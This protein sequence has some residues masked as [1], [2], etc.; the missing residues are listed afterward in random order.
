MEDAS[1]ECEFGRLEGIV[2]WEMDAEEEYT[3]VIR[4][5][6]RSHNARIPLELVIPYGTSRAVGGWV[7]LEV[8]EFFLDST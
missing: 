4:R 7:F 2:G 8:G 5:A 3:S 1:G 6:L